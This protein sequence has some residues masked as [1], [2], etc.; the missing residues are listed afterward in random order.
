M[1]AFAVIFCRGR[2][3]KCPRLQRARKP[4]RESLTSLFHLLILSSDLA[5]SPET[6]FPGAPTPGHRAPQ[7]SFNLFS[8]HQRPVHPPARPAEPNIT[9]VVDSAVDL[10]NG[11]LFIAERGALFPELD[12]G[13]E[14]DVRRS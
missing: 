9:T 11:K 1:I 4:R 14:Y 5:A 13:S 3:D 7:P 8:E 10:G 12:V 2:T 6:L